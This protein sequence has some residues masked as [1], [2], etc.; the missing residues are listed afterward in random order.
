MKRRLRKSISLILSAVIVLT[1][2]H[3]VIISS[4]V[5]EQ[6]VVLGCYPQSLLTSEKDSDLIDSLNSL[7][8]E[9]SFLPYAFFC[10]DG[11]SGSEKRDDYT[12]FADVNLGG[13]MYRAVMFDKYRPGSTY[14]APYTEDEEST[15]N[16]YKN[17]FYKNTVYWFRYE[18]ITWKVLD[19]ETGLVMSEKVLDTRAYTD[20]VKSVS[21]FLDTDLSV[22]LNGEFAAAAFTEEERSC[23]SG[24]ITVLSFSQSINERFGFAPGINRFDNARIASPSDYSKCLGQ[25]SFDVTHEDL[26]AIRAYYWID[27]ENTAGSGNA[28]YCSSLG[29]ISSADSRRNYGVRPVMKL[30]FESGY[31]GKT[32]VTYIYNPERTLIHTDYYSVGETI[33]P[34]VPESIEGYTFIG[35][36]T[37][38]PQTVGKDR[39]VFYAKWEKTEHTLTFDANGGKFA[40]DGLSAHSFTRFF[41]DEIT[42]EKPERQGYIFSTWDKPVPPSMPDRDLYLTAQWIPADDTAY[43]VNIYKQNADDGSY[44]KES[45]ICKGTTLSGVQLTPEE[46]EHYVF[47]PSKSSISGSIEPDGSSE[48]S[49]YYDLETFELTFDFNDGITAGQTYTLRYGQSITVPVIPERSGFTTEGWLTESGERVPDRCRFAAE[50]RLTW[51]NG[52]YQISFD[53]DG[54]SY[55]N[56]LVFE[57][58]EAVTPP[59]NPVKDGYTFAG[60]S[61]ELPETMPAGN[62]AVKALWIKNS[63]RI[64]FDP[65]NGTV[66]QDLYFEFS[67]PVTLPPEPEKEGFTFICWSPALPGTMPAD[68]LSVTAQ[69]ERN[70]YSVIFDTDG[71]SYMDPYTD[72]YGES[73]QAPEHPVKEGYSFI[74]WFPDLPKTIPAHDTRV[75]ALWVKNSYTVSF[76]TDGGSAVDPV[77]IEFSE[78]VALPDSPVKEG[79]SFNGW[80]T[81]LPGRTFPNTMPS[82]DFTATALWT[83]NSYSIV[84]IIENKEFS[85]VSVPYGDE[86]PAPPLAPEREGFTFSWESAPK[87]MPARNV[88]VFGSYTAIKY[89]V[90]FK[91]GSEEYARESVAYGSVI[92]LPPAP[93]EEGMI[94]AGWSPGVPDTMPARNLE[95]T[96]IF[97]KEPK[98]SI[99][100]YK[101]SIEIGYGA[102]VTFHALIDAEKCD[103]LL[104]LIDDKAYEDDGS[105][106]FTKS[107]AKSSY[108]VRCRLI[109]NGAVRESLTE[110]V[111]V[112][113]GLPALIMWLYYSIFARSRL[114]IDQR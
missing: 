114:N 70:R 107:F 104:W 23:I 96:A 12:F 90:I 34:Y 78:P 44:E 9:D 62:F 40:S 93:A 112:K 32:P 88:T 85:S 64:S 110:T 55:I 74:G 69:W 25:P 11:T 27:D 10:G 57:S 26:R 76:Y 7:L 50:Y 17:G 98:V 38:V 71:G 72:Y 79:Y 41:G 39:L 31:I 8:S 63:Y 101:P 6:T 36:H 47:N 92:P 66:K 45:T 2:L 99:R 19:E 87:Y 16:Q 46:Y 100:G 14:D 75:T 97:A 95:F 49:L 59:D 58:G 43:T 42:P 28:R 80:E 94:F 61:P 65:A 102:S 111:K 21:S 54:G 22:F 30:N 3:A 51:I 15:S 86:T 37:E 82:R 83:K 73:V 56:N 29:N 108:T 5:S 20:T 91:Y 48:F 24:N 33:T 81:D 18:P 105:R 52:R 67:K 89:N 109:S 103:K 53:T 68:N 113:T 35:W 13:V 4:A 84:Y 60:W 106:S 77:T 1:A